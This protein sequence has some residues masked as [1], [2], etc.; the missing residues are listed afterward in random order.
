MAPCIKVDNL[1]KRYRSVLAVD[2]LSFE[3]QTGEVLGLLGPNGAGKS[4]TLY[5][6]TGLVP[7]TSGSISVFGR[8]LR[9]DFTDL[10]PR[11]GVMVERPAFYGYLSARQNLLI[12]ARLA[13]CS[14]TVDLALDRAGLLDVGSRKV[15]TFSMGMRQRLGLAQALLLEP[16][17]LI[18]DEP[19]NGLDPEATQEVFSL[20]RRL[21]K[22]A[23]VTII[24]SSHML[25]EVE[26]LCDRVAIINKGRL[27]SCDHLDAL[28]SY[29]QTRVEV[30][31]DAPE[32]AARRLAEQPWVKSAQPRTGCIDVVLIEPNVPQLTAFLVGIGYRVGG[33][34]PQRRS[35]QEYFLK[36][37]NS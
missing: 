6:L 16:E 11:I 26:Q 10:I 2:A 37:M 3:V 31:V 24:F 36:V 20:L 4:T 21:A 18:L 33:V 14:V 29:D 13:G 19:A 28:L 34:I 27:V 5:M 35:L 25:Y 7:P 15:G 12:S 1:T 22:E 23:K 32:A 8:D 17:L 30:L 9:Q